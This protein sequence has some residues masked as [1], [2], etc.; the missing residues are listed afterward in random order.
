MAINKKQSE[1]D[2]FSFCTDIIT[3]SDGS[4]SIKVDGQTLNTATQKFESI[5]KN[6][7]SGYTF[8]K[9]NGGNNLAIL[10]EGEA[11]LILVNDW[12]EAK[13]LGLT[14][15]VGT[16]TAPVA[17]LTGDFKKKIDD[18]GTP[19]TSDDTSGAANDYLYDLERIAA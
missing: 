18:H 8:I 19:G 13:S 10:K 6:D 3:D 9:L 7:T 14:L 17:T 1:A 12:S 11:N 4:G 5:Y 15:Q 16:P 2:S